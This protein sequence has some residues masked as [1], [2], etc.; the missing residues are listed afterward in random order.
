MESDL[1]IYDGD[2]EAGKA[3]G[4]RYALALPERVV[5]AGPVAVETW[6]E[7]LQRLDDAGIELLPLDTAAVASYCV[8]WQRIDD[9]QQEIARDGITCASK[10]GAVY[11]HPAV[12]VENTAQAQIRKLEAKLGLTPLDRK[13]GGFGSAAK[14]KAAVRSRPA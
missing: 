5:A 2:D 4:N 13:K 10:T 9:A 11:Q 14:K 7:T 12:G 6:H 1:G 3:K 8:F